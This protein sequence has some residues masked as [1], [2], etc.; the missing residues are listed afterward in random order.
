VHLLYYGSEQEKVLH[1]Q[2]TLDLLK[3]QSEKMGREYDSPESRDHIQ[4]FIESF[5]LQDTLQEL[6]KPSLA[7]YACFNDFFARKL[8]DGARP[9]DEPDNPKVVSSPADCRITTYPTIDLACRY[10]IKGW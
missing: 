9:I 3:S 4:P 1:W 6:E 7:D 8:K 2:K 5:K 10:W